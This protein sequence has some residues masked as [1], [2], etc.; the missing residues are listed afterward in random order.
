MALRKHLSPTVN[1]LTK[2]DGVAE[3]LKHLSHMLVWCLWLQLQ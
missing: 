1:K 3:G 2:T